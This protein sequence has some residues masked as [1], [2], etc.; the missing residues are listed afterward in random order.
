MP[1]TKAIFRQTWFKGAQYLKKM[2]TF[3][4]VASVIIWALGYFPQSIHIDQKFDSEIEIQTQQ[5]E[6][7]IASNDLNEYNTKAQIQEDFSEYN[8]THLNSKE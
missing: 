4:L 6:L 2:G 1:T 5:F 8:Q 3:I 7:K